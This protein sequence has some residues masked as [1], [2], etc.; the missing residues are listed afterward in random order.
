MVKQKCKVHVSFHGCL[1]EVHNFLLGD[2]IRW[3]DTLRSGW[4][5]YASSNDII[6]IYPQARLDIYINEL[7]CFDF[8]G[9]TKNR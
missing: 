6:M 8:L 7:S 1:G 3:R 9:F 4:N 5:E 2:D